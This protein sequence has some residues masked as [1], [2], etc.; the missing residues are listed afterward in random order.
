MRNFNNLLDSVINWNFFL[1]VAINNLDISLDIILCICNL[2]ISVNFNHAISHCR[3]F[4]NFSI[5]CINL[6][7][8]LNFNRNFLDN[9][10]S[11]SYWDNFINIL[12]NNLVNFDQLRNYCFNF[13]NLLLLNHLF[14]YSF[15]LDHFG[16]FNDCFDNLLDDLLNWDLFSHSFLLRDNNFFNCW[17]FNCSLFTDIFYLFYNIGLDNFHNPIN[18]LVDSDNIFL[19]NHNFNDF[20]HH[21]RNLDNFLL[22]MRNSN[23]LFNNFL[24][25]NR[26]LNSEGHRSFNLHKHLSFHYCWNNLLNNNLSR[27]FS[28]AC[29]NFFNNFLNNFHLF[30]NRFNRYHFLNNLF[31]RPLYFN[32]NIFN[33]FNLNWFFNFNCHCV[34][35]YDFTNL[36]NLY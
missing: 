34:I 32:I 30:N 31:N 27:N 36:L 4:L 33:N 21:L 29:N 9:L 1:F 2:F 20:F 22:N 12:L 14:N 5:V 6:N 18:A 10:F 28:R 23:R 8:S 19:L 17:H 11:H 24:N 15:N 13:N 3:N 35:D 25:F 16:N 7:N 26:N